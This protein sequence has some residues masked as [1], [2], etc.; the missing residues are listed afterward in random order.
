MAS[1]NITEMVTT[2]IQ[3]RSPMIADNI[4]KSNGLLYKLNKRGRVKKFDGGDVILQPISYAENSNTQWYSGYDT[5]A[6]NAQ[7]T[8]TSAS[9]NIKQAST[10]VLMNGLERLQ[11]AGKQRIIELASSRVENAEISLQNLIALGLYSDG[12]ANG[13]KQIDGLAV[14]VPDDPTTGTYGGINRALWPFWQSKRYRGVTDGG[15]AVSAANIQQYLNRLIRQISLGTPQG[16]PDLG[17]ADNNYFNFLME[18]MQAIQRI[19]KENT[20][21]ASAGFENLEFAGI[22]IMP[23]GN[24]GGGAGTNHLWLLNTNYLHFRPH[25]DREFVADDQIHSMN[26]DA[27]VQFIL[28][29]GN[30]TCSGSRY[31]GVLIA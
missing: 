31:Q 18:S 9:F 14:A 7:D 29:A 6:T 23:D 15:A 21:M 27:T 1:P 19:T 10:A 30:L 12:T 8:F 13:G 22:P 16:R 4:K 2:T 25:T 20:D 17:V 26:Q 24:I 3:N 28:W 11:N 5:L